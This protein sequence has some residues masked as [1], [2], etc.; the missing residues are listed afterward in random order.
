MVLEW[1]LSDLAALFVE[2]QLEAARELERLEAERAKLK[3]KLKA[4]TS[5][6]VGIEMRLGLRV[7]REPRDL[8]LWGYRRVRTMRAFGVV[9]RASLD[10]PSAAG[11]PRP[12]RATITSRSVAGR[13][14]SACACAG[15]SR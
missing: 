6:L 3:V 15:V 4:L 10:E 9:P 7:M 12:A 13:P 2:R 5:R 11:S 1:S 14:N 8:W